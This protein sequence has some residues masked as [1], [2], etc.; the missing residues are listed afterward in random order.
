LIQLFDWDLIGKH[1][2]M[3]MVEVE[4]KDLVDEKLHD[5]QYVLMAN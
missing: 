4:M 3:G 1:E 2:R 5:R